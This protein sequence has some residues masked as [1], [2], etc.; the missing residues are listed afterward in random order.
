MLIKQIFVAFFGL[1]SGLMV[2]G[3]VFTVLVSVGVVTR[4]A[5]KTHTGNHVILYENAICGGIISGCLISIFPTAFQLSLGPE[6]GGIIVSIMGVFM[7]I[8]IGCFA[9]SVAEML[10][11]IPIFTRRVGFSYGLGVI[12]L[13]IALGKT[14]GSIYYFSQGI[15]LAGS[16]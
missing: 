16:K 10:D 7:G 11:G 2:A 13:S 4:L 6:L 12:I 3:G 15:F 8:F 1:S 9:I 14:V 5:G